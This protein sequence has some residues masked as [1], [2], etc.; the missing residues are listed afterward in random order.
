MRHGLGF[1]AG[2]EDEAAFAAQPYRHGLS[3][4][5]DLMRATRAEFAGKPDIAG[6]LYRAV[7]ARPWWQ[8][9][10][11][12]AVDDFVAWRIREL[13]ADAT[14]AAVAPGLRGDGPEMTVEA[15]RPPGVTAAS[16]VPS[17]APAPR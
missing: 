12:H 16:V 10:M 7:Q 13:H 1:I 6:P 17:T 5:L 3:A 8:R 11:G 4:W 9:N 15:P 14:P 2:D